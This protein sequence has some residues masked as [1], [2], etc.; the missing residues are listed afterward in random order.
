MAQQQARS[1]R[2]DDTVVFGTFVSLIWSSI[3]TQ[4]DSSPLLKISPTL[5]SG[6]VSCMQRD[7]KLFFFTMEVPSA[8]PNSNVDPPP[9]QIILCLLACHNELIIL[10]SVSN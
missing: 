4:V 9:L 7:I 8:L 5:Q 6:N 10:L 1:S 2:L 3:I